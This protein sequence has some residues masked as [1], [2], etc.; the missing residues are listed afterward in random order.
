MSVG[1]AL[2]LLMRPGLR[3]VFIGNNPGIES[4]RAGHYY[5]HPGNAFWRQLSESGLV[6]GPVTSADDAG[7]MDLAGIGFTDIC[8]HATARAA[9]LSSA[10]L[11][12]GALRLHGELVLYEPAIAVFNG[13]SVFEPF[14]R[15][16]LGLVPVAIRGRAFGAQTEM[17]AA[18]RLWMIPSSSG[19]A[20][21][22][23]ARR[24]EL[25][26]ELACELGPVKPPGGG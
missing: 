11:R 22:W 15:H 19:L 7:L 17:L 26:K 21:G 5:A 2:P 6:P 10:D 18:T 14:A 4:A 25:L 1:R 12:Q 16:A 20:S 3:L 8:T 24:L 9:E 23:R 13:R